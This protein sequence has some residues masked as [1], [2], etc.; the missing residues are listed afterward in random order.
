[1]L[2]E[3]VRAKFEEK[4]TRNMKDRYAVAVVKHTASLL[5]VHSI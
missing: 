3:F 2:L 5:V 1:M 4:C